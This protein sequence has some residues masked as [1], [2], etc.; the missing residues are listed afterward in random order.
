MSQSFWKVALASGEVEGFSVVNSSELEVVV[1]SE[2]VSCFGMQDGVIHLD[3]LGSNPPFSILWNDGVQAE[4][5]S[6]LS[7]GM[8]SVSVTDEEGCSFQQEI[9]I[10]EPNILNANFVL[11]HLSCHGSA[12]G[13]VF[14]Q[15]SGG[16][17]P[18]LFQLTDSDFQNDPLFENLTA[19]DYLVTVLDANGCTFTDQVVIEEPGA[20]EVSV[21]QV[22]PA[23]LGMQSGSIS[24][25]L[26]GGSGGDY[27]FSLD[28]G[29][30]QTAPLFD[31]LEA[32]MYELEVKDEN[33]CQWIQN[34]DIQAPP[35]FEVELIVLQPTCSVY[36]DG[37]IQVLT[38]ETYGQPVFSIN[39]GEFQ[40]DPGFEGLHPGNYQ[41]V[42]LD[43]SGCE[44]IISSSLDN[45]AS[46]VPE[47]SG[48]VAVC[49]GD[50]VVLSVTGNFEQFFWSTGESGNSIV[51]LEA[52]HFEVT[53][54]DDEGCWG[55]AGYDVGS[56][57]I[58]EVQMLGD[59]V[60]CVNE[61]S[62]L[63]LNGSFLS[64]IWSDGMTGDSM[65]VD[66]PGI[67]SANIEFAPGCW[68]E[69]SMEIKP[70]EIPPVIISGSL[71][72]CEDGSTQLFTND[73][74]NSFLWSDGSTNPQLE[75]SDA[76]I[77]HLT[78]IDSNGCSSSDTVL[79]EIS[80][81]IMPEI[82]GAPGLCVGDSLELSLQG[83]Y[84]HYLWS[85]GATESSIWIKQPGIY[86][87]T[88]QNGSSCFGE[89]SI[90][91]AAYPEV[92]V[93]ITGNTAFCYPEVSTLATTVN[94]ENYLW[95]DGTN[96]ANLN[97][98]QS[99]SYAVTV[100]DENGC[101]GNDFVI[102]DQLL[103]AMTH[104]Q[105]DLCAGDTMAFAN[106]LV[107]SSGYYI[108]TLV[109]GA[110]NGCDS[111]IFLQ[112]ELI[113]TV[114]D[115][116]LVMIP[117]GEEYYF[118]GHLLNQSGEYL[119]T[120]TSENTFC[121]SIVRLLLEVIEIPIIYDTLHFIT[122][123]NESVE[124]NGMN[125][126]ESGIYQD[127]IFGSSIWE[128][129]S[130]FMIQVENIPNDTTLL[131]YQLCSGDSIFINGQWIS[132]D[133]IIRDTLLNEYGCDSMVITTV[134]FA[135][136]NLNIEL[137][138]PVFCHGDST[139]IIEAVVSSSELEYDL[140]WSTGDQNSTIEGLPAGDYQVLASN[141]IGCMAADSIRIEQPKP[142]KAIWETQLDCK[143][144]G[145]AFL[146][147]LS[148]TGGTPPYLYSLA[149]NQFQSEPK[150]LVESPSSQNLLIED[151]FGCI[152]Q[153]EKIEIDRE[154]DVDIILED[155]RI[156]AGDT[157]LLET[158][159]NFDPVAVH[160]EGS[161]FLS[162]WDCYEPLAFPEET[163]AFTVSML[164]KDSCWVDAQLTVFVDQRIDVYIPTAFS[165]NGDGINDYFTIFAGSQVGK[166]QLLDI[167]RPVG[168]SCF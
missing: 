110:V 37:A 168:E 136:L 23:C 66:L 126:A 2:N 74:Y 100:T 157:I 52:G 19:G 167:F 30:F 44:V 17:P 99:G 158:Y 120:L 21:D 161:P 68:M 88:I 24:V 149:N 73:N 142:I 129:D 41:V 89:D 141:D 145:Q 119:D 95:S 29:E 134:V 122:C 36:P 63:T 40:G 54:V 69:R 85:T 64:Q 76:G 79:V 106:Q 11:E 127:T 147:V 155:P 140:F 25:F 90:S 144:P 87:V 46:V 8:Y 94:Y 132:E 65:Y 9:L 84:D 98:N 71:T 67:Y 130:V 50:S 113:E 35:P 61:T 4:F 1:H 111:I 146:N 125:Y 33:G 56:I 121:D 60:L 5:K 49:E 124:F 43:E 135:D 51:A 57:P 70:N 91:I 34:V 26:S 28:G 109:N 18:Y 48:P 143:N 12:D 10:Q 83:S 166:I 75:V 164:T 152:E 115:S 96:G 47:I 104:V 108:D 112:V 20:L 78:V 148:V 62:V 22:S 7:P 151:A 38:E 163:T 137:I 27:V 138:Q 81:F 101:E 14:I 153:Y 128:S 55:V 72:F 86:S 159:A 131:K 102:V 92:D 32:G 58:P 105:M 118:G 93:E 3:I 82:L 80:D 117:E 165:P 6:N 39:G 42:V 150:F 162:C 156:M 123:E 107:F 154:L 97:I 53:A 16:T 160:W 114:S 116:L 31:Q 59:S 13:Q 77:Y 133:A 15:A 139:A 103:P 45:P